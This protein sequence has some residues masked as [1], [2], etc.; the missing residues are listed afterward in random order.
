[1]AAVDRDALFFGEGGREP[2]ERPRAERQT[3]RLRVAQAGGDDRADLR[4]RGGWGPA[5]APDVGQAGQSV[6]VEPFDPGPRRRFTDADGDRDGGNRLT[7]VRQPTD[8][9]AFDGARRRGA[10]AGE[11]AQ[12]RRFFG[13][14]RPERERLLHGSLLTRR[15][16]CSN[17]L[18]GRTTKTGSDGNDC[19]GRLTRHNR[20]LFISIMA[21]RGAVV[22]LAFARAT[23]RLTSCASPA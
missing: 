17:L 6:G 15:S 11:L 19:R 4:R 5:A 2:I 21:K 20:V 18:A 1:V 12:R 14:Q 8:A 22:R 3:E 9:G 10:G 23:A 7:L 13:R 16:T